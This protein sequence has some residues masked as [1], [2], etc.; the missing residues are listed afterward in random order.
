MGGMSGRLRRSWTTT[1][2]VDAITRSIRNGSGAGERGF[3]PR[4][5]RTSVSSRC[6]GNAVFS[7]GV[8]A[9]IRVCTSRGR[10]LE[11]EA[12][13]FWRSRLLRGIGG[14]LLAGATRQPSFLSRQVGGSRDRG[15][16][17]A[18]NCRTTPIPKSANSEERQLPNFAGNRPIVLSD[19]F[20]RRGRHSKSA[21]SVLRSS[22]LAPFGIGAVSGIGA[23]RHWRPS[24]FAPFVTTT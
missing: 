2:R 24:H 17:T 10:S 9:R 20:G 19:T 3:S 4:Q 6:E 1:G 7:V 5:I 18:Q 21:V 16:G 15:V 22:G 23:V 13:E 14:A 11:L 12:A 8:S